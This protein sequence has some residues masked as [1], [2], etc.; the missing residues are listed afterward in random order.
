MKIISIKNLIL[1]Y[2]ALRST[3]AIFYDVNVIAGLNILYLVGFFFPTVLLLYWVMTNLKTTWN[4]YEKIYLLVIIWSLLTTVLK[5]FSFGFS[6]VQAFSSFFRVLNSFAVFMVFPLI[7]KDKKSINSLMNAFFIATIFPLL[8][9]LAQIMLGADFGGMRT[10]TIAGQTTE[11]IQMYYGLYHKYEGYGMAAMFG[12]LVMVYKMGLASTINQKRLIIYSPLLVLY[13]MLA[14]LTL[15]RTLVV[16]MTIVCITIIIAITAK[17]ALTQKTI[18]IGI[19]FLLAFI[20]SLSGY[21]KVRYK[22]LM[23]RTEQ[24]LQVFSGETDVQYAFD[25]RLGLWKDRLEQFSEKPLIDKLIGS[26]VGIGPHGDYITW[27]L[28]YGYVGFTLYIVLFIG[29]LLSSMR[30]YLR[31]N[32]MDSYFLRPY[33]LM[34]IAGLTV[35]LIGALIYNSSQYP[36]YSYFIIGNTAIFLSVSKNC[37]E[38]QEKQKDYNIYSPYASAVYGAKYC[39]SDN[40]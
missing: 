29:L 25:G 10:S 22:Q 26:N 36:D 30:T 23:T 1:V 20:I 12:G 15:S 19:L 9:G 40:S 33:G 7:F 34:I 32:R 6:G 14:S 4:R 31:I 28:C 37:Y 3:L 17:R 2:I 11:E 35:W 39:N 16:N 38:Y 13:L 5:I 18:I 21:A 24:E 8:Q 27:I